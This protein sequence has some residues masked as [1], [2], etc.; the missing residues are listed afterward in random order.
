MLIKEEAHIRG[1]TL[2]G[3]LFGVH[4]DGSTTG[5]EESVCKGGAGGGDFDG[6]FMALGTYH[7][8]ISE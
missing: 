7:L 2:A 3:I 4:V 8:Q 1:N 5:K 6:Q